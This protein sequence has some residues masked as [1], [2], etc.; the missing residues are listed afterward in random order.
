MAGFSEFNLHSTGIVTVITNHRK[1]KKG[2]IFYFWSFWKKVRNNLW[3][4]K[5]NLRIPSSSSS[6]FIQNR[7]VV[8]RQGT[9]IHHCRTP[10]PG[11]VLWS[12]YEV[13][14]FYLPLMSKSVIRLE[15]VLSNQETIQI[16]LWQKKIKKKEFCKCNSGPFWTELRTVLLSW[17]WRSEYAKVW[18]V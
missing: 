8:M 3:F 7:F 12:Q 17:M 10:A 5:Q 13:F 1:D 4:K 15:K 16:W 6:C 2:K 11:L 18:L 9:V 14:R